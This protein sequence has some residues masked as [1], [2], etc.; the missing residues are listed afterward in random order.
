LSKWIV[1]GSIKIGLYREYSSNRLPEED[2]V[3]IQDISS[4][5]SC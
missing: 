4:D 3:Q 5:S 2:V 1:P